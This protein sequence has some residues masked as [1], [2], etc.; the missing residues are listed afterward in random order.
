MKS[1]TTTV[2]CHPRQSGAV[3]PALVLFLLSLLALPA[4][5]QFPGF[6]GFGQQGGGQQNRRSG[7]GSTS[8]Q[9]PDNQVGD[10]YFS[11]DP[12]TR[13]LIVVADSDT[14]RWVSNVVANLNRPQ[15]QVLIKV[16]FAEVTRNNSLDIGV[17]GSFNKGS[18]LPSGLVTNFTVLSNSIVPQS[19]LP[20]AASMFTGGNAFGL[21][22]A[23]SP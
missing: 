5:A 20:G 12:N 21:A 19:I 4:H 18:S 15:P 23:G 13:Q 11:I 3:F 8:G 16:V 9:Y 1:K 22:S 7:S 6:G 14:Q 10:A 17:E 2:S